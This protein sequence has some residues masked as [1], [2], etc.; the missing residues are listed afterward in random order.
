MIPGGF[1]VKAT[2]LMEI[3]EDRSEM[4]RHFYRND[5]FIIDDCGSEEI[6]FTN[7]ETFE[8]KRQRRYLDFID[9]CY[10]NNKHVIITSEIPLLAKG[11]AGEVDQ[12][13]RDF[14]RVFG[15]AA[16]SR[17]HQMS[18]AYMCD[19]K[20]VSSYRDVLAVGS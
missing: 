9:F 1:L 19:L 6:K 3:C 2:E 4:A 12:L 17:L 15:D 16:F 11:R 5:C 10:N 7:S 8:Q 14:V 20:N 18:A 13:N